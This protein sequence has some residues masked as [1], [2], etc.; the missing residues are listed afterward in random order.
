MAKTASND[1]SYHAH[2]ARVKAVRYV[3]LILLSIIC[4]F[5]FL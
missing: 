2:I 1:K 5:S 4:L 3:V